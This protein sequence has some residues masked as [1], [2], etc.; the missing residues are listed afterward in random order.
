MNAP[1]THEPVGLRPLRR[2]GH[3]G[4]RRGRHARPSATSTRAPARCSASPPRSCWASRSRSSCPRPRRQRTSRS[5]TS[6][7]RGARR[8]DR[9][10]RTATSRAGARTAPSSPPRSASPPRHA[11]RSLGRGQR[12]R[13]LAPA[14]GRGTG[15]PAEPQ[16]PGPRS[17]QRGGG[18]GRGRDDA[19]PSD[20]PRRGRGRR[21]HGVLGRGTRARR[22]LG[23]HHGQ[24]RAP[25]RPMPR[26]ARRVATGGLDEFISRQLRDVLRAGMHVPGPVSA[27]ISDVPSFHDDLEAV[28][29][30]AVD[31]TGTFGVAAVAALPLRS[32]GLA[33]A[34]S[35]A[36]LRHRRDLRRQ[37]ARAAARRA[38]TT[39]PWPSTGSRPRPTSTG[40]CRTAPSCC[41]GWSTS[42]SANAP[43][44]PPT[45]TTS[46]CRRWPRST[47]GSLCSQK[48]LAEAAP[49]L[50]PDV[51]RIHETITSVNDGLRDLLFELEPVGPSAHLT[52]LLED[53]ATHIFE[54]SPVEWTIENEPRPPG[55]RAVRRHP[56]PGGA[57]RQ[58]GAGQRRQARAGQDRQDRGRGR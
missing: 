46:R 33:V 38:R 22:R 27:L 11:V 9:S 41:A 24:R 40:P 21:L 58:G 10:T 36:L 16:L 30:A 34:T 18:Q 44:S 32:R 57:D 28:T 52:D 6:Y 19:L 50:V 15:A 23:G 48:Q 39:S 4:G 53:A 20:L 31:P 3:R 26:S 29:R 47:C 35:L 51:V 49:H 13:R 45:C 25:R 43:G 12:A 37:P 2:S 56:H 14:G 5:G 42:R 7:L 54:L 55:A 8:R 17:A 1:S